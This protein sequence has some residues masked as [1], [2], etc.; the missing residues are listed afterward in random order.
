MNGGVV[1]HRGGINLAPMLGDTIGVIEAKGAEGARVY[2]DS[3]AVIKD[4]GYGI[5]GYLTPYKYND[6]FIDPKGTSMS[7]DVEDTRKSIVPTAGAAVH[8]KM[9]TQQHQQTFVRFT[10][11]SGQEIPFGAS[12][13]DDDNASLGMVGQGGLAMVTLPAHGKRLI[14]KWKSNKVDNACSADVNTPS[15]SRSTSNVNKTA[16]FTAM[17]LIC[18]GL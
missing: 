13:T 4:N 10:Q 11:A 9:E 8:I 7:V 3:N 17:N 12:I 18:K 6:V 16:S 5:V 2:P 15:D 14:V 1:V